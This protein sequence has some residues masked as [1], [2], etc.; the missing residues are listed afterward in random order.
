MDKIKPAQYLALSSFAVGTLLLILQFIWPWAMLIT[1]LGFYYLLFAIVVNSFVLIVYLVCVIINDNR[2][3][4]L[5][6]IGIL[7]M[8]LPIAY[9]YAYTVLNSI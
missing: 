8:N 2:K 9:C 1:I 4:S 6:A 3:A 7:L 5:K